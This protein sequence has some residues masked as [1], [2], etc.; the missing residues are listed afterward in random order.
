MNDLPKAL[1]EREAVMFLRRL[2]AAGAFFIGGRCATSL[3]RR[4]R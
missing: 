1:A 2:Q 4:P 3:W